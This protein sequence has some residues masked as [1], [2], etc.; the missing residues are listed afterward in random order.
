MIGLSVTTA[1]GREVKLCGAVGQRVMEVLR[2]AGLGVEGVCG[3]AC[4]C[5]TC[6]VFIDPDWRER[7]G[8]PGEAE[9]EMLAA[10]GEVGEVR[11]GSRLCCQVE[12]SEALDGLAVEIAPPL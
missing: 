7:V 3:G 1:D 12:L 9:A 5:G 2:D 10:I 11:E 4:S 6:H 8:A